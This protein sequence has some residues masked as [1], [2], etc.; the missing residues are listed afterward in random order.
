MAVLSLVR[1]GWRVRHIWCP[2]GMHVAHF[3]PSTGKLVP[4][5]V[6]PKVNTT[7]AWVGR[8]GAGP[9]VWGCQVKVLVN[10][11]MTV[12]MGMLRS[13]GL[14]RL[15]GLCNRG[16]VDGSGC[17]RPDFATSPLATTTRLPLSWSLLGWGIFGYVIFAWLSAPHCT[18][19]LG[20]LTSLG[21]SE[22]GIFLSVGRGEGG[23]MSSDDCSGLLS[24]FGGFGQG[25]PCGFHSG[26]GWTKPLLH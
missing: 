26:N 24:V 8:P 15:S 17:A 1:W 2:I 10:A 23:L 20:A 9:T 19:G 7:I 4:T 11:T 6:K 14:G 25:S 22:G 18:S 3:G 12:K 5:R 21:G 16:V 13:G